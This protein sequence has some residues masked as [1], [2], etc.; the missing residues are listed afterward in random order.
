M[1]IRANLQGR[2]GNQLPTRHM[3]RDLLGHHVQCVDTAG[4]LL[5]NPFRTCH[6]GVS[7]PP[8]LTWMLL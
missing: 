4:T 3:R 2:R 5:C 7:P 8:I 6:R 1:R